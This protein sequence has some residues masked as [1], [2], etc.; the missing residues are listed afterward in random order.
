MEWHEDMDAAPKDGTQILCAWKGVS[1]NWLYGVHYWRESQEY[2]GLY[3]W[4]FTA[5]ER[6]HKPQKWALIEEP[7]ESLLDVERN[8]VTPSPTEPLDVNEAGK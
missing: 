6:H 2:P 4:F 8:T 7:E 5:T 3:G 1:E